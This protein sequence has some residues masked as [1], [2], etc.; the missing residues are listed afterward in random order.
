MPYM[1]S[2]RRL[3]S[4]I[5]NFI[6]EQHGVIENF[7]DVFGGGGAISFEALQ[8]HQIE[9]VHYNDINTGVV[10]LLRKLQKDG[11]TEEFYKWVSRE[12][13]NALK[14]GDS[15]KS[16]LIKTC[17]SF[18]NNQKDYLYAKAKEE[19][20]KSIFLKSGCYV[21]YNIEQLA[22]I[23]NLN[24]TKKLYITNKSWEFI[25]DIEF[26]KNDVIY[27]DPPYADT[28]KYQYDVGLFE[29]EEFMKTTK[30]TVYLSSYEWFEREPVLSIEHKS[31]L[32]AT[33]NAKK[34]FE[35]LYCNKRIEKKKEAIQ[36]RLF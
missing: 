18:G 27:L 32:S 34:V 16:G 31:I 3:S 15:W 2:K 23:A 7:Y 11:I 6:I 4:K 25:K 8:K 13:F 21:K 12:E 17:W 29:I 30:A 5:V 10:N 19:H 9:N 33:N 26:N 24:K 22:R 14:L 1:G 28:K 35:N 36:P 20:F